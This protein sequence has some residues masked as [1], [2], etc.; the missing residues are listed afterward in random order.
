MGHLLGNVSFSPWE[1]VEYIKTNGY[2]DGD[3]VLWA[4]SLTK[5]G[6]PRF[7]WKRKYCSAQRVLLQYGHPE[8]FDPAKNVRVLCGNR[9]CVNAAHLMME[10]HSVILKKFYKEHPKFGLPIAIG[11]AKNARFGIDKARQAVAMQAQGMNL[12]EI[13]DVFGVTRSCVCTCLKNWKRLGV[14]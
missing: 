4:G 7:M 6:R 14:I 8:K 11:K 1:A 13:G 5:D 12:K 2:L 10:S 3:C 9:T